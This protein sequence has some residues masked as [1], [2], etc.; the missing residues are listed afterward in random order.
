MTIASRES[1]SWFERGTFSGVFVGA[2][3]YLFDD[4]PATQDLTGLRTVAQ[5]IANVVVDE[6]FETVT[7]GLNSPW[8]GGKST[9]LNLVGV[10]LRSR[11]STV[12]VEIDPWEFVDSGDPRG[13][14][15]ARVLEGIAVEIRLRA[16]NARAKEESKIASFAQDAIDRLNALRKRVSW[17]K[18]AQVAIKS[19]LTLTP[20]ISGMVDAL[21]PAP[22]AETPAKGMRAFREDFGALL[23]EIPDIARVVVLID[24]LDRSLPDDVLGALEAIKLFL[25]VKGM[26]FVI[27]AD[28]DFIRESLRNALDRNGGSRGQFADRYT[29]KIV[30]L[31]FTLPRLASQDAVAYLAALFVQAEQGEA[32]AIAVAE[33][34]TQRR[35]N[36][37]V[38]YAVV[39]AA[40]DMPTE[41][42]LRL[43]NQI[44]RGMSSSRRET[45]R[46]LKRFLNNFAVRAE[47]LGAQFDGFPIDVLMKLW[48]LEQNYPHYFRDLVGASAD[49]R[50][51]LLRAW[52]EG[53]DTTPVEIASWAQ[54]APAASLAAEWVDRYVSFAT[55][56][57]ATLQSS[58][59]L[60]A[61]QAALLAELLDVSELTRTGAIRRMQDAPTTG[62]E[63]VARHLATAIVGDRES[64]A[65]PSLQA[66]AHARPDLKQFIVES[67]MDDYV[68]NAIGAEHLPWLS[69]PFREVLLALR[70]RDST[71]EDLRTAIN[72]ELQEN[73]L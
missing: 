13:T 30:Q 40:G 49:G 4:N 52:E 3:Q 68:L 32:A 42:H 54:E 2:S 36:G 14:L 25:S 21:T 37:E 7:V 10:E 72:E 31:P 51:K 20:D 44:V 26:A 11:P 70:D 56:V 55:A 66:L 9:A 12:V 64:A 34:A 69:G 6:R 22:E 24:D 47:M 61:A 8:G 33:R 16:D 38:P 23:A 15:I 1:P 29:E 19:A 57:V 48:L 18:V 71:T 41:E 73:P 39:N 43:A 59:A 45:P 58:A 28:D 46:Q 63:D 27:A 60:D 35:A 65:L 5:T 17:S 50:A 62:D 53:S 67:L